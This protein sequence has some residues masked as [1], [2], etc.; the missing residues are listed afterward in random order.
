M[1]KWGLVDLGLRLLVT[2]PSPSPPS[3]S[4]ESLG[5]GKEELKV[6]HRDDGEKWA[7]REGE[8]R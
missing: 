6:E 1:K 5:R 7:E 3:K 8:S 4:F 2:R